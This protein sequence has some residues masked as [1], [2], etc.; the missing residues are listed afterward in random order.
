MSERNSAANQLRIEAFSGS[1]IND[2]RIRRG[3]L[4]YRYVSREPRRS[5]WR[6][7]DENELQLHQR[8]G[9]VVSEWM[10]TRMD[11]GKAA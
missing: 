3:R 10:R 5:Q 6:P 9:T 4:E 11:D 8:L 2:Y 1:V 7:L